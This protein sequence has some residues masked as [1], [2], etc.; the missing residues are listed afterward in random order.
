MP[1]ISNDPFHSFQYASLYIYI[2]SAMY[3]LILEEL[4]YDFEQHIRARGQRIKEECYGRHRK[5][6]EGAREFAE[7]MRREKE[8]LQ[9][10]ERRGKYRILHMEM[11][12]GKRED[13]NL[14][15][16]VTQ[17]IRDYQLDTGKPDSIPSAQYKN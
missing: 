13:F 2:P 14:T 17:F 3:E 12:A 5:T 15:E 6:L 10:A 11:S 7:C 8:G 1:W 9:E 16:S 4:K